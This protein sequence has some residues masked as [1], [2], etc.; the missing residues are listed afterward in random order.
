MGNR[1]STS[2]ERKSNDDGDSE[3]ITISNSIVQS[4]KKQNIDAL[5]CIFECMEP[6]IVTKAA[7]Y[8]KIL[9]WYVFT[10]MLYSTEDCDK[11]SR[12]LL[13]HKTLLQPLLI[14][15]FSCEFALLS[16][17][18]INETDKSE[19]TN[20]S[21]DSRE[22]FTF[23]FSDCYQGDEIY[24]M[25]VQNISPAAFALSLQSS[26]AYVERKLNDNTRMVLQMLQQLSHQSENELSPTQVVPKEISQVIIH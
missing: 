17:E 1:S 13:R 2:Q 8:S 18:E 23:E 26:I 3:T 5:T 4:F 6:T 24:K 20:G 25:S 16:H 12:L 19:A 15:R 22:K 14:E 10:S 11:M 7:K 9:Y 21:A